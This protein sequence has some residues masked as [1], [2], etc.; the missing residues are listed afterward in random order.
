MA[1]R[2]TAAWSSALEEIQMDRSSGSGPPTHPPSHHERLTTV[3]LRAFV[4]IT[5]AGQ[6]GILTPLPLAHL[7]NEFV[8]LLKNA[9]L[10]RFPRPSSLRL[11][12]KYD[13][14]LRTSGALHLHVFEQ[15]DEKRA[16]KLYAFLIKAVILVKKRIRVISCRGDP[17]FP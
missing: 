5:A 15:P 9:H 6:R 13:S 14:F 8:R 11:T 2:N 3:A 10:L 17:P 7:H 1:I 4:P 12:Q 16:F